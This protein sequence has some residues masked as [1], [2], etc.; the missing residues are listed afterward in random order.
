[1]NSLYFKGF[2]KFS[3]LLETIQNSI[4]FFLIYID[5]LKLKNIKFIEIGMTSVCLSVCD[6][7]FSNT[8]QRRKLKF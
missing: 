5:S 8:V 4:L 1:M 2:H 7:I 6:T 3:E